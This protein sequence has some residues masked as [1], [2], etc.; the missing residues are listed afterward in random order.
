MAEL[1]VKTSYKLEVAKEDLC[2]TSLNYYR[3]NTKLLL[4]DKLAS[5]A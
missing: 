5:K 4:L 2:F 3:V 1:G